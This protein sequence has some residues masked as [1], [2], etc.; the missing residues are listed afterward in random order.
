MIQ[1]LYIIIS[2]SSPSLS[3]AYTRLVLT[4]KKIKKIKKIRSNT[5]YTA[6]KK[7]KAGGIVEEIDYGKDLSRLDYD[8]NECM[9][10][11]SLL[12]LLFILGLVE[13]KVCSKFLILV[14]CK[15]SLDN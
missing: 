7:P 4:P 12:L 15:V 2:C 6:Q 3:Y 5:I 11:Q 9:F 13:K 1:F 14:A 10:D 8:V